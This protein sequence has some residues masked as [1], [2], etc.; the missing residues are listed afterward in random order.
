MTYEN[1]INLCTAIQ[2]YY[3]DNAAGGALHIVLDDGNL[4]TSH[5]SWCLNNSI[6]EDKDTR[7]F[8]IACDLLGLSFSARK[9]LYNQHW[10]V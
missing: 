9:K 8:L 1:K 7:A 4:E 3:T 10:R 2:E 5:I 6:R